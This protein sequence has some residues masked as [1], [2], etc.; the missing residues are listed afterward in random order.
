MQK[1]F[2]FLDSL[3]EE[4]SDY[5]H[6]VMVY[7][8]LL[9]G[10]SLCVR[11][12]FARQSPNQKRSSSAVVNGRHTERKGDRYNPFTS[13]IHEDRSEFRKIHEEDNIGFRAS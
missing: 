3:Q 13:F 7:S 1:R 6:R 4:K 11:A 2:Y 10:V 5:H 9:P 8:L 12:T